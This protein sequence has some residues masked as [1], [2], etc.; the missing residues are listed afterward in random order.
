MRMS[1]ERSVELRP[2]VVC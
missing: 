1:V 2:N